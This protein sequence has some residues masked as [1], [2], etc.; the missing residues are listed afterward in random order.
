MSDQAS[1]REAMP[2]VGGF[3]TYPNAKGFPVADRSGIKPL[4]LKVLVRPDPAETKSAGGIIIPDAVSDKQKFAVVKA[5]L[6]AVGP[7]AF[8]EWGDGNAPQ[9]G[10]RIL[11]AQYAG[12]R[13]KGDDEADYILMNDEDVIAVLE[14]GQ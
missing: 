6:I 7:N 2:I 11:M 1:L 3:P 12:A 10:A 9:A 4:D 14:A 5:T 13:V 8:R